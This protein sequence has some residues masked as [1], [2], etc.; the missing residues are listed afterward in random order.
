MRRLFRGHQRF[1]IM[2][3]SRNSHMHCSRLPASTETTVREIHRQHAALSL[4]KRY[5][6]LPVRKPEH[7]SRKEGLESLKV[8]GQQQAAFWQLPQLPSAQRAVLVTTDDLM[9][10]MLR[11]LLAC[12]PICDIE[13][14]AMGTAS[15]ACLLEIHRVSEAPPGCYEK[16]AL[17]PCLSLPAP[18]TLDRLRPSAWQIP[19]SV[20]QA[21]AESGMSRNQFAA[22]LVVI[23]WFMD[24]CRHRLPRARQ[25]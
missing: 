3:Q 25:E 17:L 5:T 12:S 24:S 13:A 14:L 11:S 22:V 7:V 1:D 8:R 15:T 23:L 16:T 4:N 9:L 18:H 20:G 6:P 2:V 21:V 10:S 19:V